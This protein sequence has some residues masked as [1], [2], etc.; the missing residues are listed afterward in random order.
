MAGVHNSY[1]RIYHDLITLALANTLKQS[2]MQAMPKSATSMKS[3]W[4]FLNCNRCGLNIG[5]IILK[6][7]WVNGI[8]MRP[9]VKWFCS[10]QLWFECRMS[11]TGSCVWVPRSQLMALFWVEILNGWWRWVTGSRTSKVRVQPCFWPER[12]ASKPAKLCASRCC[13]GG[14]CLA[15]LL[16]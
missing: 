14:R 8:L 2:T 1:Y 11:S 13:C 15:S 16:W 4:I 3:V 6:Q 7:S 5:N 10:G 9:F 12:S